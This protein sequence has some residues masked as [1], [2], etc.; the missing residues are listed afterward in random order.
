MKTNL[1]LIKDSLTT[2]EEIESF[3]YYEEVLKTK[4]QDWQSNLNDDFKHLIYCNSFHFLLAIC[5]VV[6]S[7]ELGNFNLFMENLEKNLLEVARS[8]DFLNIMVIEWSDML[9]SDMLFVEVDEALC[10]ICEI[11]PNL[12]YKRD[13]VHLML[14]YSSTVRKKH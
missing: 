12:K 2:L 14:D 8:T 13:Y 7:Y 5:E 9:I 11:L 3:S 1:I 4:I 10:H 6:D